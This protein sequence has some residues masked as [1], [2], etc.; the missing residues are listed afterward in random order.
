MVGSP[1]QAS[2][3]GNA[4]PNDLS[5]RLAC[6]SLLHEMWVTITEAAM[7]YRV[8]VKKYNAYQAWT[9]RGTYGSE[10]TARAMAERLSRDYAFV[11]VVDE[12]GRVVWSG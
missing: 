9:V 12:D 10:T 1:A 3:Q 6:L 2:L 11:R 4:R 7:R 5:C 8:M